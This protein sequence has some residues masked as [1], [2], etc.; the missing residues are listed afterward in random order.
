MIA[1]LRYWPASE[2]LNNISYFALL[3]KLL[4]LTNST[5]DDLYYIE[6][7]AKSECEALILCNLCIAV[8][9]FCALLSRPAISLV[10][11]VENRDSRKITLQTKRR[12]GKE[13]KNARDCK[14][15]HHSHMY[16]IRSEST[17]PV[18]QIET[19]TICFQAQNVQLS[20]Q[21][22]HIC[23]W[24]CSLARITRQ[25]L[26]WQTNRDVCGV[27]PPPIAHTPTMSPIL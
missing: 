13:G 27:I 21:R 2:I 7:D 3:S 10:T 16:R 23:T 4:S 17:A 25:N 22:V 12:D 5:S 15:V 1:Q 9:A 19:C 18:V 8:N 11:S 6:K 14:N 20:L 26:R 24:H